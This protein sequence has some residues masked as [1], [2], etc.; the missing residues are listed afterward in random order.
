MLNIFSWSSLA[1]NALFSTLYYEV[2]PDM[3]SYD[4]IPGT[5]EV[6]GEIISLF[7][8]LNGL[9]AGE[10]AGEA[11]SWLRLSNG[12]WLVILPYFGPK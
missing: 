4:N 9:G 12:P 2:G 7:R 10:V 6:I 8:L 11:I 3:I 5:G 1:D